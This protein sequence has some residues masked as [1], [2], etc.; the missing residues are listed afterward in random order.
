MLVRLV[1]AP[2][3]LL[4]LPGGL[5]AECSTGDSHSATGPGSWACGRPTPSGLLTLGL[6]LHADGELRTLGNANQGVFGAVDF[7]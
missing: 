6:E 2:Y 4:A 7:Q 5:R 1:R 3:P